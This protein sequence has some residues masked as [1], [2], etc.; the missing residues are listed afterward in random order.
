MQA[1][2]GWVLCGS[3]SDFLEAGLP[4]TKTALLTLQELS[5]IPLNLAC[6][7]RFVLSTTAIL[8]DVQWCLPVVPADVPA[9]VVWSTF[10]GFGA[11]VCLSGEIFI[12]VPHSVKFQLGFAVVE[13]ASPS[14]IPDAN[15]SLAVSFLAAPHPVSHLSIPGSFVRNVQ[16]WR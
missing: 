4:F 9:K 12:Q 7:W 5:T 2:N 11:F 3:R 8:M 13:R 14:Q 10:Q 15:S 1:R 6:P 16:C